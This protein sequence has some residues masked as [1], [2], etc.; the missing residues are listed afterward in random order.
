MFM[1]AASFARW[2]HLFLNH[3]KWNGEQI[4]SQSYVD[5]ATTVQVPANIEP[6]N[7]NAGYREAPGRYGY[8]WWINGYGG[9]TN[10]GPTIP[11]VLRFPDVPPRTNPDR[12]VYAA[13]GYQTN[14]CV[15]I[16]TLYNAGV[17]VG[18]NMVF[19]RASIGI[20]PD[21]RHST[22]GRFTSAEYN[23]FLKMLG[24]AIQPEVVL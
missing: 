9:W 22:P 10:K 13:Q 7:R 23:N 4:I 18:A 3:G 2:G 21:G 12:G 6:H 15:V 17:E 11:P 20:S 5:E 16:H 14:L 1:S 19:A 24:D 8:M